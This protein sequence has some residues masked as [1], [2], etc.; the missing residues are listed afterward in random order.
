MVKANKAQP[1]TRQTEAGLEKW[2][3]KC[4]AYRPADLDHFYQDNRSKTKLSSWCRKCQRA[5]VGSS[6]KQSKPVK[7]NGDNTLVLDFSNAD[8]LLADLQA[9]AVTDFRS[10]EMQALYL[11]SKGLLKEANQNGRP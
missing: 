4:E 2:C 10:T 7:G 8:M 1:M 11:I 6:N 9:E 3:S 5:S